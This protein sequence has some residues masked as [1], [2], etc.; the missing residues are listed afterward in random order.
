MKFLE[1][2]FYIIVILLFI[3][4]ITDCNGK[5]TGTNPFTKLFNKLGLNT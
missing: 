2:I 1:F 3:S 5:S 4:F